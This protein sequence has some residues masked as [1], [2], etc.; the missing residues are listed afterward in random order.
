M[1]EACY[2]ISFHLV[3]ILQ[4]AAIMETIPLTVIENKKKVKNGA[5]LA[6][7]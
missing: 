1:S 2:W 4:I 5:S 7:S 3:N 6:N